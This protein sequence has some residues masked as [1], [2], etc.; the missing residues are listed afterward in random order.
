MKTAQTRILVV[1]DDRDI[2]KAYKLVLAPETEGSRENMKQLEK[3]LGTLPGNVPQ[4][5]R[6]FEISFASQGEEGF[7]MAVS[8]MEKGEPFALAFV[9]VRMPP[10]WDGMETA[11]H[12]HEYDPN[13]EI[14]IVTAYS[15]RS[16]DDIVRAVGSPHRILFLRKP[17]DVEELRRL[18]VSLVD[19]WHMARNEE[20]QFQ[21]LQALLRTS[22][23]AIYSMDDS[24]KILSWNRAAE[25]ITGYSA[26]EV[27]DKNCIFKE[28]SIDQACQHCT[29]SCG[30]EDNVIDREFVIYD[31]KGIRKTLSMR[32]ACLSAL[33]GRP[34]KHIG[35]FWDITTI[36]EA[37][38][39]LSEINTQLKYEIVEKDRLQEEQIQLERK[40]RQAEKMEAIGLM[41]GGVAHDLNNIL[42]G[43]V[44]YPELLLRQLPQDSGMRESVIAISESGKRAAAV[45]ADLL[46]VARGANAV[47]EIIDL[48]DLIAEYI[49]SPEGGKIKNLYPDIDLK[50][51][52]REEQM[53]INC[54]PVHIKKSLMNLLTNASEAIVTKG[55]I[56]ITT[57][58]KNLDEHEANK[59][60]VKKGNY[61]VL[62]V[63]DSGPGISSV[64]QERIFEPFY[65]RKKMGISGTGLGLSVVWNTVKDHNGAI[66]LESS[67]EGTTFALYFPETN[68]EIKKK[69][70]G[71]VADDLT[72][73]GRI[74]V[75][76]DEDQ[77]RDIMEKMLVMLGYTVES[78]GSGEEAVEYLKENAVDLV[79]L[80]MIMNPGMSGRETYEQIVKFHP[81]QKALMVSGYSREEEV[82][83][84]M[85][86]GVDG[87]VKKPFT[88]EQLGM[89]VKEEIEIIERN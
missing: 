40:L 61:V 79:L 5:E 7:E 20:V 34:V 75:V 16:C 53:K 50:I 51:Q 68:A 59:L 36:K 89:V 62:S 30:S 39:Q 49:Q 26:T 55:S 29:N 66:V 69:K 23:A 41:A 85:L 63:V 76:D 84:A 10:G 42:S 4:D 48:N 46:T 32:I 3:L 15:D 58:R 47:R 73:S 27:I 38:A 60:N 19:K 44:G 82:Q 14:V 21:E 52:L 8:S 11:V 78:V 18:A 12:L 70:V 57:E 80:D 77:Q 6:Q 22:P 56:I 72:G 37:Q 28:I 88:M 65:T 24:R 74:L 33:R 9:D 54:S 13:L 17:F 86:L 25:Q 71:G 1:D 35:S 87:F 83:K 2:W 81:N 43:L 45:V 67:S 31:K 64:D